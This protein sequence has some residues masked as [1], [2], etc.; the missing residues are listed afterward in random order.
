M[1]QYAYLSQ[2]GHPYFKKSFVYSL[3]LHFS[4]LALAYFLPMLP[5]LKGKK[6]AVTYSATIQVDIVELPDKLIRKVNRKLISAR[7]AINRL[8]RESD[9]AYKKSLGR[10]TKRVIQRTKEQSAIER[11]KNLQKVEEEDVKEKKET[12]RKGNVEAKGATPTSLAKAGKMLDAYRSLLLERIKLRWALPSYL[13]RQKHLTGE[14]VI[15]ISEDG[16]VIRQSV[17]SSG[18][19]EFDDYMNRALQEA[20]PFPKVP[21]EHRK[22]LRYD[23]VSIRFLSGELR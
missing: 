19:F 18:N 15:F 16:S 23:G 12:E 11:L 9:F 5:V 7:S 1:R 13:R 14:L 3:I 10:E 20:L 21:K 4:I 6:G 17:K 22:D 8:R 2:F